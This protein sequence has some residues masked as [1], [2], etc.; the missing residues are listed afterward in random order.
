MKR[1]RKPSEW[2][3]DTCDS[4]IAVSIL[5][6]DVAGHAGYLLCSHQSAGDN[7]DERFAAGISNPLTRQTIEAW[8]ARPSRRIHAVPD[9]AVE[10]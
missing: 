9:I 6:A 10:R 5:P 7:A 8:I 4:Y 3:F 2:G 1:Q